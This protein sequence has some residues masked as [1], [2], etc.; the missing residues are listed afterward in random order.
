[1]WLRGRE[2]SLSDEVMESGD[3]IAVEEAERLREASGNIESETFPD[4]SSREKATRIGT[5]S[6]RL[7]REES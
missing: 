5:R 1:M 3:A 4:C 2:G 7:R 6:G